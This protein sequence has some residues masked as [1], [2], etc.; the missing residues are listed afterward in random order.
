MNWEPDVFP[1]Q[2]QWQRFSQMLEQQPARSMLWEARP[3]DKTEQKLSGE[4]VSVVVF[5]PC[6]NVPGEG[7]FLSVMQQNVKNLIHGGGTG[8]VQGSR[9]R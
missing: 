5:V 9:K 8:P 7:D 1:G 3:L 2:D 6:M 4:G